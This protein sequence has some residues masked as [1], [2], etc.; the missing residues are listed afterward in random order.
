[1]TLM[2]SGTINAPLRPVAGVV[3]PDSE[4]AREMTELVKDTESPLLFHHSSRVYYW[5]ALTGRRRGLRFDP[6]LLYA[7]AMP[8]IRCPQIT[9][10]A[11]LAHFHNH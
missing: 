11:A 10:K 5:G 8:Q 1:M 2:P 3:I 9:A 7:G 4:L 6:E